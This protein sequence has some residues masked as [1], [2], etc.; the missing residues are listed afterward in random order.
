[1]AQQGLNDT[2]AVENKEDA[3]SAVIDYLTMFKMM[4][5]S[6]RGRPLKNHQYCK[7][8][9]LAT[10]VQIL[11]AFIFMVVELSGSAGGTSGVA[12]TRNVF[13]FLLYFPLLMIA[14]MISRASARA[15]LQDSILVSQIIRCSMHNLVA[16]AMC[17]AQFSS[18]SAGCPSA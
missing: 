5:P 4:S 14:I 3:T 18:Q 12:G 17:S 13:F 1:M 11:W 16:A 15:T 10:G 8:L 7:L 9:P 6:Y 2:F